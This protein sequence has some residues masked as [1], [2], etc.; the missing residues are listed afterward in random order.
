MVRSVINQSLSSAAPKLNLRSDH[1]AISAPRRFNTASVE[2]VKEFHPAQRSAA[3]S[4]QAAIT[5]AH[6]LFCRLL[7][8]DSG[9]KTKTNKGWAAGRHWGWEWVAGT[10]H[11]PKKSGAAAKSLQRMKWPPSQHRICRSNT[12]SLKHVCTSLGSQKSMPIMSIR[13][14]SQV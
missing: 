10:Y 7:T 11:I 9:L 8:P 14:V 3:V 5:Y 6:T 12:L 1:M 13:T 2:V 4:G